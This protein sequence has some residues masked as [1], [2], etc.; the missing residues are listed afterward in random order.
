MAATFSKKKIENFLPVNYK[1]RNSIRKSKL[2][3]EPLFDSYLFVNITDTEIAKIKTFNGVIN[4]VYWK[5]ELA[6]INENEID[7]IREFTYKYQDI[8]LVKTLINPNGVSELVK[9][10]KYS[11]AG[12]LLT[13]KNTA[14]K[15]NLP[16]IGFTMIAKIDSENAIGREKLFGNREILLQS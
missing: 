13:V 5:G 12:N 2:M 16:S 1:Q 4:F 10:H 8:H 9:A 3:Y 11:M 6:T 15:L 7:A 14:I